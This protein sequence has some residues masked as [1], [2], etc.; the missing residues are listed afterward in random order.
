MGYFVG[1]RFTGADPAY[2]D[3]LLPLVRDVQYKIPTSIRWPMFRLN[4]MT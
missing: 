2:L 4:T 1:Y 3:K